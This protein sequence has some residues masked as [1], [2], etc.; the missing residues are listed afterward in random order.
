[1]GGPWEAIGPPRARLIIAEE[2]LQGPRMGGAEATVGALEI[3]GVRQGAGLSHPE[4]AG[5]P[6]APGGA[7]ACSGPLPRP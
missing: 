7:E 4:L 6:P 5:A 3:K 2:G 1:M